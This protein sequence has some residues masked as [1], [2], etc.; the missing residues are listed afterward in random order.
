[1]GLLHI[2]KGIME[3][4]GGSLKAASEGLGMG[5]HFTIMVPL[6]CINS[7]NDSGSGHDC[8]TA[9]SNLLA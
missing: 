6:Y 2:A 4:H 5:S 7:G 8:G 1:L 3:Q 9:E